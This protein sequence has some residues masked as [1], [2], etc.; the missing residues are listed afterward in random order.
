MSIVR[1]RLLFASRFA[2][3]RDEDSNRGTRHLLVVFPKEPHPR[4]RFMHMSIYH[5]LVRSLLK[6]QILR[7]LGENLRAN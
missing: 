7:R 3:S 2:A 6:P 4:T 5:H 1:V